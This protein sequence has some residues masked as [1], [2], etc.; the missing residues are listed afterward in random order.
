M[1]LYVKGHLK[2]G[3]FGFGF[4]DKK[5]IWRYIFSQF[6]IESSI[7]VINATNNLHEKTI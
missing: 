7:L 3:Q 4:L 5:V 1:C 2:Q 6:M